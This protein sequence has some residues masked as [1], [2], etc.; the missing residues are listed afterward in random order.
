MPAKIT[1]IE[2]VIDASQKMRTTHMTIEVERVEKLVLPG[3][4]L[5]HHDDGRPSTD[6]F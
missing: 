5:T 4:Q 2:N 3:I 6:G 1:E